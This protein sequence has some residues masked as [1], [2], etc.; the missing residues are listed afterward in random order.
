[1][2]RFVALQAEWRRR[3]PALLAAALK[4][5]APSEPRLGRQLTIVELKA[6]FPGGAL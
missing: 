5:R 2:P 6:A 1:V 4:Y 3:P